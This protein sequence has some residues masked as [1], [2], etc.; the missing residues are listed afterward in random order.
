MDDQITKEPEVVVKQKDPKRVAAGKRLAAY[1]KSKPTVTAPWPTYS[2]VLGTVGVGLTALNLY[3][4]YRR[5]VPELKRYKPE[6]HPPQSSKS[7]ME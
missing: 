2:L 3:L 7:G 6:P 5:S 4:S 1:N